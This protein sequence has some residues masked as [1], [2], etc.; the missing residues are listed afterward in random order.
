MKTHLVA[1]LACL[2]AAHL[3]AAPAGHVVSY[4][5][6]GK[7]FEG[8]LIYDADAA[9][10]RRLPG[11]VMVPNWMGPTESSFEK[12][13]KIA[14]DRY[15]VFVA[16]MYGVEVR[17]ENAEEASEAAGTVRADRPM[18]RARAR[19][20]VEVF[21][22]LAKDHPLD[23]ERPLAI[24][25]CFGG[26]TVLEL[27]RGGSDAVAGVVSFHGSLGTPDPDD[28]KAIRVPVLVLHGADDPYAPMEEVNGFVEE[29][30]NAGE[31]DWQL[32]LFGNTVHS[33]TDPSADS[34]GA[35]YHPESARRAF[36]MMHDFAD[37]TM[38]DEKPAA[39]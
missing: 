10:D 27:A 5:L 25:F 26:G 14:G 21:Q 8:R 4:E 12:A 24:G 33:F 1:T 19:K 30:Q 6:D 23:P 36:R 7:A 32:M 3:S 29:M 34:D 11:I 16:D 35:R 15:A 28:A 17:P 39:R 13:A 38:G 20:A 22:S 31:V 9:A 37:E 18:M 2:A